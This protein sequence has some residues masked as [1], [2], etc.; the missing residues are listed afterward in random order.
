MS[1][2]KQAPET[3]SNSKTVA[4]M[5]GGFGLLAA[6][7]VVAVLVQ[8]PAG[9]TVTGFFSSLMSLDSVHTTWYITRSAG[10]T[11]YLVLW[12]SV[13]SGLA[14]SSKL[15]DRLLHRAFTFDFH[16]FLSLLA[17]GTSTGIPMSLS[18]VQT[19]IFIYFPETD[20]ET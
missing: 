17:I 10:L 15:L 12:F 16:E 20:S 8:T 1:E 6:A 19:A 9:S 11:A 2:I 5:L 18:P 14:V 4:W 13:A 3:G 7:M